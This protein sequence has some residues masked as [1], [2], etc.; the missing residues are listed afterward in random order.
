VV[1][2]LYGY[3]AGTGLVLIGV[4]GF[5]WTGFS[6][7]FD[8]TTDA[9]VLGVQLNPTQNLVHLAL[10][11]LL[12]LAATAM[13]GMSR[14]GITGTALLLLA[15]AVG[16]GVVLDAPEWNILALNAGATTLHAVVG[17]TGLLA[18]AAALAR[19]RP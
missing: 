4:F 12:L 16:G 17:A 8:H 7:W 18:S 9:V 13:P 10:G 1:G 14:A 6:G 11:V 3:V 2:R 19:P 5:L 15:L